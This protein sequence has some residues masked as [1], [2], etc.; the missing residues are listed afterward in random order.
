VLEAQQQL[1]PAQNRLAEVRANR[2]LTYVRLYKVLGGSFTA[3]CHS[4]LRC[5]T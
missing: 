5:G 3:G 2:L 4:A 1:F